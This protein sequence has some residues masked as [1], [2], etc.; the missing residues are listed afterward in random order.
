[1]TLLGVTALEDML[2]DNVY[3]CISDFR[4][5]KIK[6]WMLTGDKGETAQ[7]IGVSCG[8]IDPQE[9]E[10]YMIDS[11][12]NKEIERQINNINSHFCVPS[13]LSTEEDKAEIED[14]PKN[15]VAV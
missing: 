6:V 4:A 8:L 15:Q 10:I 14:V 5:A 7:S 2:Q 11:M 13:K 1:M 9:H 3:K 12:D